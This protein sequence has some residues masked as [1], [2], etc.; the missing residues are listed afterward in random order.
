M[1][2]GVNL[3][4]PKGVTIHCCVCLNQN[5]WTP[6]T[7]IIKGYACCDEHVELVS[8]PDFDIFHLRAE[9]RAV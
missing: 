5:R 1:I 7:T 3:K 4:P 8:R 6:A 2:G 9:F